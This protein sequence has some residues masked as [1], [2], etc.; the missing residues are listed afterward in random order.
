MIAIGWRKRQIK[1]K[2]MEQ[3]DRC[4]VCEV[5]FKDGDK[6]LWCKFTNCPETE[7]RKISD[8]QYKWIMRKKV[9][10]RPDDV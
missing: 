8:D 6:V 7:Q 2:M 3:F 9:S 4:D 1:D 5:A 10:A